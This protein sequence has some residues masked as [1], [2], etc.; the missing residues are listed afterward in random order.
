MAT[1][2]KRRFTYRNVLWIAGL[3]NIPLKFPPAHPFNTLK[4]LRLAIMLDND[5]KAIATI[6]RFIWQKGESIENQ[7]SWKTLCAELKA[8]NVEAEILQP[9]VKEALRKNGE[10]A[11][12]LGVFGVPTAVVAGELFWGFDSTPMLKSYLANPEIFKRGEMARVSNLPGATTG[13]Q[14]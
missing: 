5:P 9:R 12:G 13:S 11:V 2:E 3:H 10:D 14:T 4:A 7:Q 6:F 1:Q 8:E